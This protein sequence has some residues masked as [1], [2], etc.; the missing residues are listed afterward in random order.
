MTSFVVD[1][2]VAMKWYVPE[3][4]AGLAVLL[5]DDRLDLHVPDL[6]FPE[7]GNILWKKAGRGELGKGE[8]IMILKALDTVPIRVHPTAGAMEPALEIA[9]ETGR[10]VYDCLYVAL[11]VALETRM[12][13]ADERLCNAL[14]PTPFAD[15]VMP[16][17]ELSGMPGE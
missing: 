4:D 15:H 10:T 13:T 5:L 12:V 2:S 8:A 16:L 11:A 17:R 3:E 6:F 1:A 7:F 14:Q 9:L